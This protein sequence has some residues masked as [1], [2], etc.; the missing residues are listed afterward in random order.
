MAITSIHAYLIHAGKNNPSAKAIS[1]NEIPKSGKLFDML[2][3]IFMAQPDVRDFEITFNPTAAGVKQND[4]RDLMVAFQTNPTKESGQE[5]A[6][7][8]QLCTDNRSGIGL[9]FLIAGQHG[10][11]HR[12]VVSRFPTDKAILA[13]IEE[14]GLAVEFLEQ[15]FIKRLSA[16]KALLLE[17]ANPTSGFWNGIATDRQAGGSAENISDYWIGDFLNADFSETPAAGTKRLAQVLRKAIKENPNLNVKSEIASA[18]T[19][20]ASTFQGKSTSIEQFCNHFGFSDGTKKTIQNF[21][22]KPGLF[23]KVFQFDGKEFKDMAPYRTVEIDNGA[24]LTAPSDEFDK[25]F[26]VREKANHEVEYVTVGKVRDQ[27]LAR[28]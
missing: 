9:L 21:L 1:A 20:A 26:S 2:N 28:K 22:S 24:I 16:Y 10:L 11:K 7:R 27:R 18:T 13:E 5:I 14:G 3:A 19:L 25:V 8:L 4:C 17:H 12:L 6:K 23:T 15:V